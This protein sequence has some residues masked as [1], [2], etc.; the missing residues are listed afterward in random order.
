[1]DYVFVFLDVQFHRCIF[2][3]LQ[4]DGVSSQVFEDSLRA[5]QC[6][7]TLSLCPRAT[8]SSGRS[9]VAAL[10]RHAPTSYSNVTPRSSERSLAAQMVSRGYG[11]IDSPHSTALRCFAIVRLRPR[12]PLWS[13]K[14]GFVPIR[15]QRPSSSNHAAIFSAQQPPF[16]W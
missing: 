14:P 7:L 5:V 6:R 3:L 13:P 12:L 10:V 16:I 15:G 2:L 1:M 9:L 11:G 8:R 4:A